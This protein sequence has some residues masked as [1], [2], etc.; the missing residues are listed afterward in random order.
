MRHPTH[1][2]WIAF[3]L[4]TAGLALPLLRVFELPAASAPDHR[5]VTAS[6][7]IA[8]LYWYVG[9]LLLT[10]DI[11]SD[12]VDPAARI[13]WS[14]G[15]AWAGLHT[16]IA[17]HAVHGWS[18][19]A[20]YEHTARAG[21]FGAGIYVNYLFLLVWGMDVG[22]MWAAPRSFHQRPRWLTRAVLG[23]L[24]FVVFNA[25]V[26]F[27]TSPLRWLSAAA[28][29]LLIWGWTGAAITRRRTAAVP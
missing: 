22:L 17:F 2:F 15:F 26:V 3:I 1:H 24:A 7:W 8:A 18:H 14:A 21:G 19:V 10:G 4:I 13:W 11:G 16:A 9:A 12:R 27:A 23:F 5:S 6:A 29:A 25:T 20:A 28:F